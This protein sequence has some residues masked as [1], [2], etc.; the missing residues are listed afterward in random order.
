[1]SAFPPE[2]P[3]SGSEVFPPVEFGRSSA[4]FPVARVGNI[5]FAML[6]GRDSRHYL[7]SGRRSSRPLAEW[8]RSDFYGHDGELSDEPAFALVFNH[9]A[10]RSNAEYPNEYRREI[11]GIIAQWRPDVWARARA[12]A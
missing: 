5:V 3:A 7:A 2:N 6:L 4:G 1:M 9:V 12:T 10:R 11:E 8:R